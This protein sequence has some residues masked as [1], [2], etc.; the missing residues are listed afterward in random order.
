MN[1]GMIRRSSLP[2]SGSLK[3]LFPGRKKSDPGKLAL[4]GLKA[5]K[6]SK[7]PNLPK[8]AAHESSGL[9]VAI[10]GGGAGKTRHT[11]G[12][13]SSSQLNPLSLSDDIG[14][15]SEDLDIVDTGSSKEN[16]SSTEAA[17]DEMEMHA[18]DPVRM[19]AAMDH[20]QSKIQKVK[21]HIKTEQANKESNVNEYLRLAANADKQQLQRIKN[22]FEK[23]NQKSAQ[24]INQMQKKLETYHKRLKDVEIHGLPSHKH[25]KERLQ[26]MSQGLN[27]I[28]SKPRE[29]AHRIIK[30]KSGSAD[31]ISQLKMEEN[32]GGAEEEGGRQ[33]GGTLPA[34]FKYS[35]DDDNSSMTSGSGFGAHSSPHSTSQNASQQFAA[36]SQS[37]ETVIHPIHQELQEQRESNRKLQDSMNR[38]L[39]EF[40][41]YKTNSR[42]EMS[43]LKSLLD[44]ERYRLSTLEEQIN[45]MTE[46]H[47][48]EMTNLRQDISSMEEKIEYQLDER[49]RDLHD[50]LE[51]CQ[52]RITKMELQQQ[53]QQII[54]MEMVD[55][56][57]FRTLLTKLINVA[58]ALIA[59]VLVFVSTSANL[60][61]PFLT[62]RAR[63]LS[64]SVMIVVFVIIWRQWDDICDWGHHIRQQYA[65]T[66]T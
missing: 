64:S 40:D 55:N 50:A 16:G 25:P 41:A 65:P 37:L 36:M 52:T 5:S 27:T 48:N 17:L 33:G 31:N 3:P 26:A 11:S 38:M 53:Q 35:S 13:S 46:L 9:N 4:K 49:T 12:G 22:V 15:S 30:I 57:T 2:I 43:Q 14:Q 44:D 32:H 66:D 58:L 62:T 8:K 1:R 47:Q 39:E 18:P 60:L 6:V 10:D 34:S 7:S 63:I 51:N 23:K 28:V 24:T 29:L 59:V 20:L 42:T 19:R 61:A 56:V 54:S 45:D 21:S